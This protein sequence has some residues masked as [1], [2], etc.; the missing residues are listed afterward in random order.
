M[1]SNSLLVGSGYDDL[2]SRMA[3]CGGAEKFWSFVLKLPYLPPYHATLLALCLPQV[4][5]VLSSMAM[6]GELKSVYIRK[7]DDS[8]GL[9]WPRQGPVPQL[10]Q[11]QAKCLF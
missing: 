7:P 6:G 1:H 5:E 4:A 11:L 9:I 10:I 2:R 8:G 3:R